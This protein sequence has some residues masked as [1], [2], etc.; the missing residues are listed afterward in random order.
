MNMLRH[1]HAPRFLGQDQREFLVI[2][3][4]A[5]GVV[6]LD[7]VAVDDMAAPIDHFDNL[8]RHHPS[9]SRVNVFA[10][11]R[12]PPEKRKGR[13]REPPTPSHPSRGVSSNRLE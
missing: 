4:V 1:F 12:V 13:E 9:P 8:L 2:R 11:S 10:L 3:I 6:Q 7:C 5:I